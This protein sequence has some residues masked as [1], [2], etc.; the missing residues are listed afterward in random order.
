VKKLTLFSIIFLTF[1]PFYLD[2]QDRIHEIIIVINEDGTVINERDLGKDFFDRK[3]DANLTIILKLKISGPVITVKRE[4]NKSIS[5]QSVIKELNKNGEMEEIKTN[6]SEDIHKIEENKI[7]TKD[8]FYAYSV[9]KEDSKFESIPVF[10]GKKQ[11]VRFEGIG[12]PAEE[13]EFGRTALSENGKVYTIT[14]TRYNSLEDKLKDKDGI[15]IFKHG[16]ETYMKYYFGLH[17]GVFFPFCRTDEYELGFKSPQDA[18]RYVLK[19]SRQTPVMLLYGAIYPWGYE[20]AK[21]LTENLLKR[22]HI[23]FGTELSNSICEKIYIGVG[24]DFFYFSLNLFAR[25]G[26]KNELPSE[27][28]TAEPVNDNITAIP[29]DNKIDFAAGV[30]LSIPFDF[31][32]NWLGKILGI[33]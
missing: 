29:F 10:T 6:K 30:A 31:A 19:H 22:L 11:Q 23:D 8:L 1:I 9:S 15:V 3:F 28:R 2:A 14:I 18:K 20:P 12:P 13:Q 4:E 5:E 25:I 7:Y 16:F 17:I 21:P 24:Y 26:T 33:K 27:F 32:T